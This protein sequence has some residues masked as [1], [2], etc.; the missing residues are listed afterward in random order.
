MSKLQAV[1]EDE[2][3]LKDLINEES[4]EE[5]KSDENDEA[6]DRQV[7][8]LSR[9]VDGIA[10]YFEAIPEPAYMPYYNGKTLKHAIIEYNYRTKRISKVNTPGIDW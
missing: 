9:F 8:K 5:A 2:E 3:E 7:Q 4:K 1:Y 10:A 6:V